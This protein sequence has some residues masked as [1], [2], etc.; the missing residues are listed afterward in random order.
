MVSDEFDNILHRQGFIQIGKIHHHYS[1]LVWWHP[2]EKIQLVVSPGNTSVLVRGDK[3]YHLQSISQQGQTWAREIGPLNDYLQNHFDTLHLSFTYARDITKIIAQDHASKKL[4]LDSRTIT[5]PDETSLRQLEKQSLEIQDRVHGLVSLRAMD[6]GEDDLL[7]SYA[8]QQIRSLRSRHLTL[9]KELELQKQRISF[10]DQLYNEYRRK[11]SAA[12]LTFTIGSNVQVLASA[13]QFRDGVKAVLKELRD[14]HRYQISQKLNG[15]RLNI[16]IQ[17]ADHPAFVWMEHFLGGSPTPRELERLSDEFE[18]LSQAVQ[19]QCMITV[20]EDIRVDGTVREEKKC[21]AAHTVS[22]L[23]KNL[24]QTE[25]AHSLLDHCPVKHCPAWAGLMMTDNQLT[26]KRVQLP[27]E[28]LQHVYLSGSTGAGKSFGGRVLIEGAAQYDHV[29][30]LVLDPRN[31]AAGLLLPEDRQEI[32]DAYKRFGMKL[33]AARGYDFDYWAPGM[34]IGKQLP[35]GLAQLGHGRFIISFKGMDDGARC[36]LARDILQKVLEGCS[37]EESAKVRLLLYVDEAHLF[38]KRHV[39][40][41]ARGVAQEAEMA[42]DRMVREG[43][44]YGCCVV[45]SSQTI[46][47][48]TYESASIRQNTNTKMFLRNSDREIDYASDFIGDGRQILGLG[49]GEAFLHNAAWG[50]VRIRFRPPMS[51][52]AGRSKR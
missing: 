23:L 52:L 45:I 41:K 50:L 27:L 15:G 7:G 26:S 25:Q 13:Q 18:Q 1:L 22:S 24:N 16:Q 10:F 30:I 33:N 36:E 28:L 51:T 5:R 31:Q 47:D 11:G 32:L 39:A 34:K 3:T 8:S 6:D 21:L 12:C 40:Q 20:D 48:F 4:A 37:Q 42:L 46:R 43:R 2:Q 29:N 17:E 9:Q 44:K 38:T 19:Q 35:P 49:I 14:L